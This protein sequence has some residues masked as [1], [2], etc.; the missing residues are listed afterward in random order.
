M[1]ELKDVFDDSK[2]SFINS[3]GC[4]GFVLE[5]HNKEKPCDSDKVIITYSNLNN[6]I[7]TCVDCDKCKTKLGGFGMDWVICD[8]VLNKK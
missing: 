2:W 7:T 1:V 4:I 3:L 8:K 5:R 6:N